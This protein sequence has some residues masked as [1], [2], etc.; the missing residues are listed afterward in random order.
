MVAEEFF[1]LVGQFKLSTYVGVEDFADRLN[2][3]FSVVILILSMTI[4]TVKSYFFNPLACYVSITPSGTNFDI[5]MENY[6]WVHGTIAML[7]GESM[8]QNDS[9]WALADIDRRISLYSLKLY[10]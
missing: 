8:P 6:C 4:V 7:P 10:E 9:D 2:F 5:Y 1:T 3:L